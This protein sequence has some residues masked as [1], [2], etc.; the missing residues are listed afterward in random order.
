MKVANSLP[1]MPLARETYMVNLRVSGW[2][3]HSVCDDITAGVC[4]GRNGELGPVI[5][6]PREI[7]SAEHL[8]RAIYSGLCTVR[9]FPCFFPD[10]L[11]KRNDDP[12]FKDEV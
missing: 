2:R 6:F 9:I 10:I 1:H 4:I 5:C 7:A 12:Y 11:E 3:E 8:P